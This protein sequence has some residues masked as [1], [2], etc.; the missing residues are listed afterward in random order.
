[1]ILEIDGES[2]EIKSTGTWKMPEGERVLIPGNSK[3][4]RD[5]E[6]KNNFYFDKK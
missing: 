3:S 2:W 1:M 4:G 5:S 6:M